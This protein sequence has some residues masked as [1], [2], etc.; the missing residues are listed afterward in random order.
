MAWMRVTSKG[1]ESN[2]AKFFPAKVQKEIIKKT[3]AKPDSIL[4]FIADKPKVTNDILDR[5]RQELAK[6]MKLIIPDTLKYCWVIDYP[7]FEWDE[8]SQRF[9]PCHH[10]FS[11]PKED[12]I[13]LL[14]KDPAKVKADLFDIVLNG[15]ELG[16]G[17]I[18]ISQ[19]DLQKRVMKVIGLDEKEANKKFGFLLDAYKYGGP[20]HGGMGLGFD[21]LVTILLGLEDIREVIAFPKNKNAECPMDGCPSDITEEQMK[22]LNI[23]SSVVKK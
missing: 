11:R 10:I 13:P 1:L 19:P 23:K 14:E 20:P 22:E 15:T 3:K 16:S 8:E 2:I 12:S 21:R 5:L 4:M 18:R 17:S 7:L 6:R 9:T